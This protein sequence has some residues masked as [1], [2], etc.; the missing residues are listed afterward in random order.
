MKVRF[1]VYETP[2]PEEVQRELQLHA[3]IHSKGTVRLDEL[4]AE[5]RELGVNSAQIKAVLDAS[6]K[7]I[8]KWLKNGYHVELEGIGTF[9]LS[10]RS[11][12]IEKESGA[13]VTRV[14]VD[15][16]NFKSNKQLMNHVKQAYLEEIDAENLKTPVFSGRRKRMLAYLEKTPYINVSKYAEINLCSRYIARKDLQVYIDE[17]ILDWSGRGAHKVYVYKSPRD[18][19]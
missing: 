9:S 13:K 10:L 17:G 5:L 11:R 7:F 12:P 1:K 14:T 18:I 8:G 15:R 19:A 2:Q 16:V 4:C 6:G 3:R